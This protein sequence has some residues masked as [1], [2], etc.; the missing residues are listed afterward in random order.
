MFGNPFRQTKQ[1]LL[2]HH[3][4]NCKESN[5]LEGAI[6]NYKQEVHRLAIHKKPKK[7]VERKMISILSLSSSLSSR[8][9]GSVSA[10]ALHRTD[11]AAKSAF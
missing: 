1:K 5:G 8:E 2:H 7:E 10:K 4:V 11:F 3:D 6:P 9:R